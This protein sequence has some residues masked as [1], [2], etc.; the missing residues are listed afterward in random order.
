MGI[1]PL[2]EA[3]AATL[4]APAMPGGS[5]EGSLLSGAAHR[6]GDLGKAAHLPW[7]KGPQDPTRVLHLH[8]EPPLSALVKPTVNLPGWVL[9]LPNLRSLTAPAPYLHHLHSSG[10]L[11]RLEV[12]TLTYD[13]EWSTRIDPHLLRWPPASALAPLFPRLRALR[14]LGHANSCGLPWATLCHWTPTEVGHHFPSLQSLE[15]GLG[16]TAAPIEAFAEVPL[17]HIRAEVVGN[18]PLYPILPTT[19]A[20]LTL[21]ALG[22]KHSQAELE[23]LSNLRTLF[24]IG[25]K[26]PFDCALLE[27]L[28]HLEELTLLDTK[29]FLNLEAL[30]SHPALRSLHMVNCGRPFD[31]AE[32]ARWKQWALEADGRWANVDFC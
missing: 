28:P 18:I 19:L 13:L 31:K 2:F 27:R 16:K 1:C 5:E 12:L 10:L 25:Q 17:L 26:S 6:F 4:F 32:K 15:T 14:L 30:A 11:A 21:T 20:H 29:K 24:I 23:R 3:F 7:G 9:E 8:L 22:L